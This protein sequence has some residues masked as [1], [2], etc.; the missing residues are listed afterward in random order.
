MHILMSRVVPNDDCQFQEPDK[1]A[2]AV[3]LM[4]AYMA[5]QHERHLPQDPSK[6]PFM[7][8]GFGLTV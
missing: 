1:L 8:L 6:C 2:Y 5:A 3:H 7:G 4:Q